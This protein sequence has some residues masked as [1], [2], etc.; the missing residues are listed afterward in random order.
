MSVRPRDAIRDRRTR[1]VSFY[2]I[3]MKGCSPKG[4][5]KGGQKAIAYALKLFY[6]LLVKV[7]FNFDLVAEAAG[8][9]LLSCGDGDLVSEHTAFVIIAE[10]HRL[11]SVLRGE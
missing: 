4:C 2:V 5:Q 6:E 8:I 9:N 1:L 10:I 11:R 7:F 3:T